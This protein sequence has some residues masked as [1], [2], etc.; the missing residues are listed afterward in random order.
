MT[1]I[2][3]EYYNFIYLYFL[4]SLENIGDFMIFISKMD[5]EQQLELFWHYPKKV[6]W[7]F[8]LVISKFTKRNGKVSVEFFHQ[9]EVI[10]YYF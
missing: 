2:N 6:V 3:K 5:S 10:F 1:E 7:C 8:L 9:K 4:I